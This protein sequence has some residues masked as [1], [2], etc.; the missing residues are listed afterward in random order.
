MLGVTN[1]RKLNLNDSRQLFPLVKALL[2][3]SNRFITHFVGKDV[4]NQT[5]L[6]DAIWG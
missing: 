5:L 3:K 4:G 6:N 1:N 2:S